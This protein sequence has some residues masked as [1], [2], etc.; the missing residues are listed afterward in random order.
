MCAGGTVRKLAKG[1]CMPSHVVD[2]FTLSMLR[3]ICIK[4]FSR[5]VWVFFLSLVFFFFKE[6]WQAA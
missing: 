6:F 5:E 3:K 4:E 1:T 2:L